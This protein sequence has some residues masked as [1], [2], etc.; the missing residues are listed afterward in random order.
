MATSPKQ[1][2]LR[3]DAPTRIPRQTGT[4]P[5]IPRRLSPDQQLATPA[6]RKLSRLRDQLAASETALQIRADPNALAPERLLVFELTGGVYKFERAVRLIDGL[7]FLGS[8]DLEEDAEDAK[9]TVYLMVPSEGAL[10]NIESLWRGWQENQTVPPGFSTWKTMLAQLRDVR[11]WGPQDRIAPG[12]H[13]VLEAEVASGT[14]T[15][16]VEIE[17]VFRRDGDV[18]EARVRTKITQLGGRVI[19]R[20]RISGAAY[21]ALL[22]DIPANALLAALEHDPESIA[23]SEA[24]LQIRPQS[25]FQTI[26]QEEMAVAPEYMEPEEWRGDPIAA[27]FDAVPL[28]A[29]P[30]LNG[31]LNVDDPF[32]LEPLAVGLREHGTAMA[33][34]VIHGDLN[35]PW[36]RSLERPIH[37]VN[38][39]YAGG[40]AGVPESFPDLLPADMFE[41]AVARMREGPDPIAPH[42]LIVNASLGDIN[43]PFY[44]RMS[45]WARVVDFLSSKYGILF[46]ISAGNHDKPLETM[47]MNAT[48]FEA[49]ASGERARV[50]LRAS[51]SQLAMR[52]IL[53]PAEAINA[54]TVGAHHSDHFTY[55]RSLP[56]DIFDVW[57]ETGLCS[58][59][60]GLGPGF[61]GAIKPDILAPGGKHHVRLAPSNGGHQLRPL[62]TNA[63]AFGGVAVAAPPSATSLSTD[64]AARSIGT[65]I[66]A[67]LVTG[68]AARAHEA[69]EIAYPDFGQ[70]PSG[71]RA[72]LLKALLIHGSRWT[73]A[74]DMI[75]EI[76]GPSDNRQHYRQKDNVR[77]YLGYGAYDPEMIINCADDRATLWAVGALNADSGQRFRIP[78]PATMSGK[79][80][81]HGIR[82]TLAWF[83]PPKPGAVA[84]RA[85]RMKILEP[86]QL[87]AA[88]VRAAKVQPDPKQAHKGTVVHRHWDGDR[89][90]AIAGTSFFEIDVQRE[91]DDLDQAV[92]FALVV[93]LEM[94]GQTTIYS[95]ILNCVALKPLIQVP[96]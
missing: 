9:P 34:A 3:L 86:S 56:A 14:A 68:V 43:K 84:Y 19:A 24:V 93:T 36:A 5:P 17:L 66:S 80:L 63:A 78:W 13:E 62:T 31:A 41:I 42:V 88:G 47:G 50:A 39:L 10:K 20:S 4:R 46:V 61:N 35:L 6:G 95:D 40:A 82:A 79:A 72:A 59:S 64:I 83:S 1:P 7:E 22:A 53:A 91:A 52:R 21:H 67:A 65:S 2:L 49:L 8:E 11:P 94:A 90:A 37:F 55:S 23:G 27:I 44:N 60:S 71:Q 28:A 89:A 25:V 75:V 12:D 26:A 18:P 33:S 54:I 76:L 87:G 15:V 45:G 74:R 85:V 16:R 92:N 77:R 48:A 96:T 69:L 38:M 29:H 32:D 58:I 81:P 57:A 30:R 51:A 70:L 73:H